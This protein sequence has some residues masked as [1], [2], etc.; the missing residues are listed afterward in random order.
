MSKIDWED[1]VMIDDYD[2]ASVGLSYE[3]LYQAFKERMER[4]RASDLDPH[5]KDHKKMMD[6]YVSY[7]GPVTYLTSDGEDDE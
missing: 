2:E 1:R 4:E 6:D 7:S 5:E 3:D